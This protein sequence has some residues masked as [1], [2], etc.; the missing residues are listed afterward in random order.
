MPARQVW[1]PPQA[2]EAPQRDAFVPALQRHRAYISALQDRKAHEKAAHEKALA[3]AEAVRMQRAGPGA[4]LQEREGGFSV[5]F[6][7]A[8]NQPR[9]GRPPPVPVARG[10]PPRQPAPPAAAMA[11]PPPVVAERRPPR[12]AAARPRCSSCALPAHAAAPLGAACAPLLAPRRRQ[13]CL[14][15]PVLLLEQDSGDL[16]RVSPKRRLLPALVHHHHR[17]GDGDARPP[18]GE[19]AARPPWRAMA[20]R[21]PQAMLAPARPAPPATEAADAGVIV[22]GDDGPPSWLAPDDGD[23]Q[24]ESTPGGDVACADGG[25][26]T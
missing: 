1:G 16:L 3:E 22:Y 2:W 5:L 14:E 13:W 24:D 19:G 7:G 25:T 12:A 17:D 18:T 21:P 11:P 10:S 6:S 4:A 8:N 9:R 20:A 23:E 26:Q 15:Q